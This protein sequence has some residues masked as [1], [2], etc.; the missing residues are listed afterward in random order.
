MKRILVWD[1]PVRLFHW[2]LAA[3]IL[4][5]FTVANVVDDESPAFAVHMLLGLV[6][7]FLV[8]LRVVWGLVGSRHARFRDFPLGPAALRRYL[9]GA[10]GR[11]GERH[12]GH[13]PATSHAALAMFALVLG[14]GATGLAMGAGIEAAEEL[15]EF[16]AWALIVVAGAHVAGVVWH[17]LRHRENIARS[18]VDGR[19]EADEAQ[20]IRSARPIAAL[21]LLALTGGWAGVLFHGYDPAT[22]TV[23][24]PLG[25]PTLQLGDAGE[26]GERAGHHED[27]DDDDD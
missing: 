21:L 19:K 27:H 10:F 1:L 11:S 2:L 13:N 5:A 16:L 25:G 12:V 22:G 4:V 9:K 24:L 20:G 26:H 6:A 3:A 8:V 7:G 18:M 17:T 14:L 15:H 23:V